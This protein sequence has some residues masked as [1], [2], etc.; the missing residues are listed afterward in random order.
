MLYINKL[1]AFT[2]SNNQIKAKVLQSLDYILYPVL[3][4][5]AIFL[6]YLSFEVKQLWDMRNI[7][8]GARYR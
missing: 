4:Q 1:Y 3:K 8:G 7:L 2:D 5:L 6:F